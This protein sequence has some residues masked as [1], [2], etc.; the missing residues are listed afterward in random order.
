MCTEAD[1]A[2]TRPKES[3]IVG[4]H[5]EL[6]L[7]FFPPENGPPGT[8]PGTDLIM[9]GLHINDDDDDDDDYGNGR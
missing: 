7:L 4:C 6:L 1:G 2:G 9:V 8:H 5:A 3:H